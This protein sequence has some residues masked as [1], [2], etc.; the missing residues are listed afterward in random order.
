MPLSALLSTVNASNPLPLFEGRFFSTFSRL[1]LRNLRPELFS[2]LFFIIRTPVHKFF[3]NALINIL[4][5]QDMRS[6]KGFSLTALVHLQFK[7][8]LVVSVYSFSLG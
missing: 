1:H 7:D 5:L 8:L 3:E 2:I 4:P 6:L